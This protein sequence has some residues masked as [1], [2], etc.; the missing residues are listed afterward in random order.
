VKVIPIYGI[1]KGKDIFEHLLQ[2]LNEYKMPLNKLVSVTTN[3]SPSMVGKNNGLIALIKEEKHKINSNEVITY[4]CIIHEESLCAKSANIN[5]VMDFVV[6]VVNQ[7]I[8]SPLSHRKFQNLMKELDSQYEDVIYWSNIRWLSRGKVLRRF[9]DLKEKI[10][11]FLSEK[12]TNIEELNDSNFIFDLAFLADLT[13]YLNDL[14]I[15]LQG[16]DH[17]ITALYSHIKAFEVKLKLWG[18]QLNNKNYTHFETCK[19]VMR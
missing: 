13:Q 19:Q 7:I 4:H 11:L 6:K 3:S 10:V 15:K 17:L 8:T 5:K 12:S 18:H 2:V 1:T 14:N 16:R 9:F